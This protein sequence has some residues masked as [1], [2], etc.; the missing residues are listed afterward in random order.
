MWQ[1]AQVRLKL[2]QEEEALASR[3][4]PPESRL[5][6]MV[7]E[8]VFNLDNGGPIMMCSYEDVESGLVE[9]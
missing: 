2:R 7:E 5:L 3:K 1:L 4:T 6:G 9:L 8:F